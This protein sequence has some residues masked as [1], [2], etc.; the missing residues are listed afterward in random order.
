MG[1]C[2]SPRSQR[3]N[4]C[5]ATG[6]PLLQAALMGRDGIALFS[7]FTLN[8]LSL[9]GP[10][11]CEDTDPWGP[12][13]PWR[14]GGA[15]QILLS[16]KF[17]GVLQ[18]WPQ[19]GGGRSQAGSRSPPCRCPWGPSG[20]LVGVEPGTSQ[21]LGGV[22]QLRWLGGPE[23]WTPPSCK[24]RWSQGRPSEP[25]FQAELL[26]CVAHT[27]HQAAVHARRPLPR[28][29]PDDWHCCLLFLHTLSQV[30]V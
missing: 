10:R 17:P 21:G 4:S 12:P 28:R 16:H 20:R 24:L 7:G 25:P 9:R 27:C 22:A 8:P 18:L 13:Q 6:M 1:G 14:P 23:G 26:A 19:A 15:A 29:A 2:L 5:S 11:A 3:A 30:H